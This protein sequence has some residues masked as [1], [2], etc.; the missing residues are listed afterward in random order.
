MAGMKKGYFLLPLLLFLFLASGC[1]RIVFKEEFNQSYRVRSGTILEVYN[2]NGTVTI[3]GWDQD[4][5]E[6]KAVKT[7]YRESALEEIDIFIDIADMITIE[8]RHPGKD[9]EVCV[10]Y[11]IK[12]PVDIAVGTVDCANGAIELDDVI[13]NPV[14]T[15]SNGDIVIDKVNGIVIASTSNG[16]IVAKGA[17]SLGSLRTSN[18]SIEAE[19]RVIHEDIDIKTSNGDI[20]LYLAPALALELVAETANGTVNLNNLSLDIEQQ[21]QTKLAGSMNGGGHKI[22]IATSNGSVELARLR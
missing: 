10:N 13:G 18:G 14:L 8:T 15:T 5:V 11:V 9:H 16:D 20:T 7:S 2:P 4:E 12:V 17:R 19:L 6:I 1:D 3:T 21:E 22:T